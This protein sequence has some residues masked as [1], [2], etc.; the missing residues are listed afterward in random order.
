MKKVIVLILS[1]AMCFATIAVLT[2][3]DS[4]LKSQINELKQKNDDLQSQLDAL[5]SDSTTKIYKLGETATVFANGMPMFSINYGSRHF[6]GLDTS[7]Y[8]TN[9]NLPNC[10]LDTVIAGQLRSISSLTSKP[11]SIQ[12]YGITKDPEAIQ[13]THFNESHAFGYELIYFYSPNLSLTYAIF[14]L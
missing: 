7:F 8:F 13:L 1:V 4:A 11:V 10:T 14:E 2:G 5:K 3:C 12:P 6:S 9:I